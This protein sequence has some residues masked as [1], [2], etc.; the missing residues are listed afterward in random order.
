MSEV[1]K[2]KSG[3]GRP[4]S[5]S[6]KELFENYRLDPSAMINW[7][8][9][10]KCLTGSEQIISRLKFGNESNKK[11]QKDIKKLMSLINGWEK[12]IKRN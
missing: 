3:A 5:E 7:S 6:S 2:R 12:K 9:L 8:E 11:Y 10:S 4:K 1:K